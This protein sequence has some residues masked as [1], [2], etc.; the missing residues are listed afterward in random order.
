MC[1]SQ[2]HVAC[3]KLTSGPHLIQRV[4]YRTISTPTAVCCVLCCVAVFQGQLRMTSLGATS[5]TQLRS[6]RPSSLVHGRVSVGL[7][8]TQVT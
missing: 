6:F 2:L 7:E 1:G 3:R 8:L 4:P 5:Q